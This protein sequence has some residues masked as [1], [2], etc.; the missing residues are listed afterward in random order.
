[1]FDIQPSFLTHEELLKYAQMTLDKKESL[2]MIWQ[3]EILSRLALVLD[4][5]TD[6]LR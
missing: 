5:L 2:P 3:Q 1:M 6:D 4:A